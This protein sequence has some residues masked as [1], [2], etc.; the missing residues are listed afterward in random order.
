M[1]KIIIVGSTST[2]VEKGK[3]VLSRS[4]FRIF[5]TTSP[6]DTLKIHKEEKVDLIISELEL[7][8]MGGDELCSLIREDIELKDVA[9]MLM[10]YMKDE[11]I[12]RCRACGANAYITKPIDY[13]EFSE[14]VTG[15]L[16]APDRKGMRVLTNLTVD[17]KLGNRNFY[18]KS[19]DISS[20]GI[21]LRTDRV[22]EKGDKV[23]CSFFIG[24]KQ[25]LLD[26]EIV[27]V[28]TMEDGM[29]RYGVKFIGVTQEIKDMIEG[30]VQGKITDQS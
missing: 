21:L 13:D 24:S 20:T 7:L 25:V 27:R 10:C 2:I 1:K 12:S 29:N 23:E 6:E 18:A 8:G 5:T 9:I 16:N 14:K 11:S 28:G 26:G 4:D 15:L 3:N 30:F 17:G 19:E 22:L